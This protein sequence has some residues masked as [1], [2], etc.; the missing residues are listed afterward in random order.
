MPH[1]DLSDFAALFCAVTGIASIAK[2]QLWW[3]DIG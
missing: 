1:G 2:P 3:Q